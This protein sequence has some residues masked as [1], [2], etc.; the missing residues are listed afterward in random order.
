MSIACLTKRICTSLLVVCMLAS[1]MNVGLVS[2]ATDEG[3]IVISTEGEELTEGLP[4]SNENTGLSDNTTSTDSTTSEADGNF[5]GVT[6]E[7]ENGDD[8]VIPDEG[9]GEEDE[10]VIT[11]TSVTS[12]EELEAALEEGC[13]IITLLADITV[14]RTF[15]VAKNTVIFATEDVTLTRDVSFGGDM[16]LLGPAEKNGNEEPIV[17]TFGSDEAKITIDGNKANMDVDV[18]GTVFLVRNLAEAELR[19]VTV[20]NAKKVGNERVL[21]EEAYDVTYKSQVGGAAIILDS[22][23]LDIYYSEFTNNEVGIFETDTADSI[24]GRGA[25]IYSFG[26]LNVYNSAFSNNHATKGGAIYNYRETHLNDTTFE[27]NTASTLGGAVYIPSSTSA[28][29]YTDN[30]MFVENSATDGGAVFA[31]GTCD[32]KNTS[33][34]SNQATSGN[35]GAIYKSGDSSSRL[36]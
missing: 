18:V 14:D 33:F 12:A 22:G 11:E 5:D 27:G 25:A 6:V 21:D 13:D 17:R 26:E 10:P 31:Y 3:G 30:A 24:S 7:E 20:T 2:Y 23:K 19:G 29:L 8:G 16:F 32:L 9:W 4:N 35:G 28:F 1:T 15:E 34:T 36:A